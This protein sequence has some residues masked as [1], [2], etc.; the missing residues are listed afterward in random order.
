MKPP[1]TVMCDRC[2]AR[3]TH[4]DADYVHG[5]LWCPVCDAWTVHHAVG[6]LL[7]GICDAAQ[8]YWEHSPVMDDRL[9]LLGSSPRLRGALGQFS[10]GSGLD[11]LIPASAGSTR[12]VAGVHARTTAHPRVCGEHLR[13]VHGNRHGHGSSPR[14]RGAHKMNSIPM[15][16]DRLIP[17]SAGSTNS[18]HRIR[19]RQ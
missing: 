1:I 8:P 10:G 6:T 19:I 15:Q 14:L 7:A 13:V 17:A 5:R 9:P 11:G 2:G 3:N 16:L 4:D 12:H 18:H